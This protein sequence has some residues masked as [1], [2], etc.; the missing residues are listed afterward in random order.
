ML[1]GLSSAP[2]G[3]TDL[4]EA[5]KGVPT[6][7]RRPNPNNQTAKPLNST[8]LSAAFP[9]DMNASTQVFGW[10]IKVINQEFR[11]VSFG[12]DMDRGAQNRWRRSVTGDLDR[13]AMRCLPSGPVCRFDFSAGG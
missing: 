10:G 2:L 12:Y 11:K 8:S 13:L 4:S 1:S 7:S 5:K 9:T 6:P 3:R